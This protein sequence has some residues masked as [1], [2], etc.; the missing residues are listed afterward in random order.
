MVALL[1]RNSESLA[2]SF[3]CAC[4][5][6]SSTETAS[7]S[8]NWKSKST[9]SSDAHSSPMPSPTLTH[10]SFNFEK[11][12]LSTNGGDSGIE[13][14]P[15]GSKSVESKELELSP[16]PSPTII[17]A[18]LSFEDT[19]QPRK[20]ESPTKA[21]VSPIAPASNEQDPSPPKAEEDIVP[22]VVVSCTTVNLE[23]PSL[24]PLSSALDTDSLRHH[25]PPSPVASSTIKPDTLLFKPPPQSQEHDERDRH[26]VSPEELPR[27]EKETPNLKPPPIYPSTEKT[28]SPKTPLSRKRAAEG[29]GPQ[30]A[31]KFKPNPSMK[32]EIDKNLVNKIL[33]WLRDLREIYITKIPSKQLILIFKR[34]NNVDGRIVSSHLF[35]MR[36]NAF[37]RWDRGLI[38]LTAAVRLE[39][40]QIHATGDDYLVMVSKHLSRDKTER[41]ALLDTL[42]ALAE[43]D[44]EC[45]AIRDLAKKCYF[46]SKSRPNAQLF[47]LRDV[48]VIEIDRDS[49]SD[50]GKLRRACL[51]E[52]AQSCFE[53]KPQK[54]HTCFEGKSIQPIFSGSLF[55]TKDISFHPAD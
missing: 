49:D 38:Q 8:P 20:E 25:S 53:G 22:D 37:I 10:A 18:S 3:P 52:Q 15:S 46:R 50:S 44:G 29:Q 23:S 41:K 16:L 47:L 54:A 17:Y 9:T 48:G 14:S 55:H 40:R 34:A 19:F 39:K 7:V 33:T 45:M 35:H 36:D 43:Q 42:R 21:T 12:F 27:K 32:A 51:S 31:K 11:G 13:A 5:N 2:I 24:K 30:L 4:A 28:F 6:R 1:P 26:T